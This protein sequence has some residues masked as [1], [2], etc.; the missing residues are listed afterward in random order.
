ML[1]LIL[2]VAT[3]PLVLAAP[4]TLDTGTQLT[5]RGSVEAQPADPAKSQKNFDLTLWILN[6]SD[7]GTELLWLVEETGSG[8]FPWPSRLGKASLDARLNTAATLPGLLFDRGEDNSV[9]PVLLPFFA[10]ET[11]LA[12]E[13]QFKAGELEHF[14]DKATRHAERAAWHV[15]VRD[16]FGPKRALVVDQKLPL[17][18][19]MTERVFMGRGEEYELSL[20]LVEDTQLPPAQL[21]ALSKASGSLLAVRDKLK[22]AERAEEIA[23]NPAQAELLKK[24]LPPVVEL[25]A[26]TP[27]ARLVTAATRDLELQSGRNDAVGEL[28]EKQ[29]GRAVEAFQMSGSDG[30]RLTEADLKGHV[31]VLHFWDYRDEPLREPYGQV[32]YLD[33]LY[34]RRQAEGLRVYGVAVS[35]RLGDEATRPAAQR[36]VKKFKAF[37]NLSYPV[38]LDAGGLLKQFGDPRVIGASLPLFVVIGPE[39]KIIHYHVGTYE[40]Q[41][42]QGLAELD[43]V[44][45]G[46]MKK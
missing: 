22:L 6:K 24:E 17:V 28:A 9:V 34:H 41:R 20:E 40:V 38:L 26:G 44:V 15:S 37:M 14:V 1:Q 7:A 10:P 46:A 32:G 3:A 19:K 31:T 16:G 23:W 30:E 2:A 39:G 27:L 42:D 29:T 45:S 43:A 4:A 8:A 21:D 25:A 36:S 33:F 12:A 11:P 18:L 13:A 35:P 5:Y